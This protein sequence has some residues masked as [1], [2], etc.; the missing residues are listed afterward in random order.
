MVTPTSRCYQ[1]HKKFQFQNKLISLIRSDDHIL[2]LKIG[3]QQSYESSQKAY[4]VQDSLPFK[5][6]E[7]LWEAN[8]S[9]YKSRKVD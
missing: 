9:T 7:C 3:C 8:S 2:V 4:Q 6:F 5:L 1:P